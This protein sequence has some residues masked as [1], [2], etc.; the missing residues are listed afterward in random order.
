LFGASGRFSFTAPIAFQS[1]FTPIA[2]NCSD[3]RNEGIELLPG[4]DLPAW[5]GACKPNPGL[6]RYIAERRAN[7][8]RLDLMPYCLINSRTP[9]TLQGKL[10]VRTGIALPG[11]V[12]HL[13][14]NFTTYR[15]HAA[16]QIP[17]SK[18]DFYKGKFGCIHVEALYAETFWRA[19]QLPPYDAQHKASLRE[20]VEAA[21]A[22]GLKAIVSIPLREFHPA[23]PEFARNSP[24]WMHMA[25]ASVGAIYTVRNNKPAEAIM[26]LNSGWA[27]QLERTIDHVLN[28][29]PWDGV[30]FDSARPMPCCHPGH[31]RGPYHSD[32]EGLL[33]ILDFTRKRTNVFT[34]KYAAANSIALANFAEGI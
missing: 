27:E 6:G 7:A 29:L 30:Y 26:C 20:V 14:W 28:D 4:C 12:K 11:A 5:D 19:G 34:S 1:R 21:H 2:L 31:G 10:S 8:T 33:R 17:P 18:F 22:N 25:A 24:A 15:L 9:V 23:A 16:E 13:G 3:A 32:L